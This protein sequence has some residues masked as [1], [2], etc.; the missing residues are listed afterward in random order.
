MVLEILT[1]TSKQDLA[2]E[3]IDQVILEGVEWQGFQEPCRHIAIIPLRAKMVTRGYIVVGLNPRRDFDTDHEQ[4]VKA[5]S[6]Q[7]QELI[8]RVTTEEETQ[9]RE[10]HLK[11]ELSETERRVNR[12]AEVVPVGI[13]ELAADGA[14]IWANS[15]FWDIFEVPSHQRDPS[16]FDWQDYIHPEDIARA[17]TEMGKSLVQ[18]VAISDSLRLKRFF[19][20]PQIGLDPPAEDEPFWIMYAASPNLRPDGTVHSLMGSLTNISHLK[21]TQ[22]LHIRNAEVAR[23]ERQ[24]QEE[25][26][27]ITSHE[28]RNPLSAI[29]QCADSVILSLHDAKNSTDTQSLFDII[30]LNAEAAESILF[31]AAHQRRIID[32]VLTLGKLDSKLLTV[33]PKAFHPR[34]LVIQAVQMFGTE[35]EVNSIDLRTSLDACSALGP[36]STVYG[37]PS[38]LMQI[39]V[40]LLSNAIKFTR[41][42]PTREVTI[43]LGCTENPPSSEDFG[44]DFKWYTT[45]TSRPDLT[46]ESEY[47][48]GRV[49][50]LYYAVIDSGKGIP[51][52]FVD[53]VFTKFNQAERRTHTEY[54]GSGLGL[55]ISQELTEMQGG[56]IGIESQAGVGSTFAF[57]TK[58]RLCPTGPTNSLDSTGHVYSASIS[59]HRLGSMDLERGLV[60]H[61]VLSPVD[62][63]VL[64]VEDNILNQKILTKQLRKLGCT[65]RVCNNGGEAI[66]SILYLYGLPNEYA[67][68][69]PDDNI[70]RFDCI[71]MDWEMPVCDGIKASKRIRAIENSQGKKGHMIIGVTAN[72]RVEQI[73]KAK[74]AGMDAVLPKPFRVS[75]L[76][77]KIGEL[78]VVVPDKT[79][80]EAKE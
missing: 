56:R 49:V 9:K 22:Q 14:L 8:N 73:T 67:T 64:L 48:H 34:D 44:P 17:G 1:V 41:S 29:T 13:Y 77:A 30:K 24:R 7:L 71:L 18:A 3:E 20:P 46:L 69:P 15:Q 62:Y 40:N 26:I 47:G 45:G 74:D 4:F 43:R 79:K 38:R 10:E 31:C 55:Y 78:I 75:E 33:S 12:L 5:V 23:R 6:R 66:D 76:L 72:A 11:K 53:S 42:R 60:S 52:E 80:D 19:K 54:G 68:P 37:D 59:N 70:T 50:Y 35:C 36:S 57:Y 63:N 65:V 58:A 51:P 27:D 2:K 28:M 32:D 61:Q 21:W 39:M 16:A 25:F